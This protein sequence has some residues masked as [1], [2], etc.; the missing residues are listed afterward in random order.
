MKNPLQFFDPSTGEIMKN[1]LGYQQVITTLTAVGRKV[2]EQKFYE[3]APADYVPV[4]MG[5][6]AYKRQILNWRTYVK[7]EG[8]ES[9]IMGNSSN[10]A[11]VSLVDAAYDSINQNVLS[12]AKSVEYN[13]FELQEALQAN[14]LFSLIEARELARRKQWD[15]GIQ[16]V[17]FLGI[18]SETGLLN[19]GNVTVDTATITKRIPAMSSAEFNTFAGAIY[20]V[21]RANCARTARP[22]H[23]IIPEAD[24]NGLINFP[25]ATY[26]LKTKLELLEAAFKTITQRADF[27]ILPNAYC[28]KA[29]FD[30]TNNRYVLLNYDET[31]VKMDI[32]IDYTSTA[33]GTVNGFTWENV[34]YGSFTGVV[35]QREK[36]MLYFGNTAT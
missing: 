3:I 10:G 26:P 14:T 13:L 9:G 34:A 17:A 15:L 24:W 28:D 32:P 22:T 20:E 18:G 4:V 31:S 1:S 7:G 25:D 12:W 29:N 27:K 30:T 6:G 2:S 11:R 23:F 33:A 16:K 19:N 5:N 36:E 8:F 35:A 21:Y